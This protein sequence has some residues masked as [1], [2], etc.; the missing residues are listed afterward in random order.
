MKKILP[1]KL[2]ST[3][4]LSK[5][6][7]AEFVFYCGLT[8]VYVTKKSFPIGFCVDVGNEFDNKSTC[9]MIWGF[10]PNRPQ[11]IIKNN[12]EMLHRKK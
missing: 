10:V 5:E 2:F 3:K 8:L 1:E 6:G 4:N 12:T 7:R 9:I 11:F